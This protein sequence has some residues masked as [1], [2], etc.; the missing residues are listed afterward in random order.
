[1]LSNTHFRWYTLKCRWVV[2]F[3]VPIDTLEVIG[4]YILKNYIYSVKFLSVCG[5]CYHSDFPLLGIHRITGNQM[6][7]D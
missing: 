2:H 4:S 5:F 6:I 1:M 3:E 7:M